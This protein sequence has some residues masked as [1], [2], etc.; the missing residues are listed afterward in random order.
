MILL[1]LNVKCVSQMNVSKR[2]TRLVLTTSKGNDYAVYR[3]KDEKED[4]VYCNWRRGFIEGKE[5]EEVIKI[6][7]KEQKEIDRLTLK[8]SLLYGR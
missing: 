1:G 8:Q 7:E 3:D 6:M 5:K 2:R 4:I